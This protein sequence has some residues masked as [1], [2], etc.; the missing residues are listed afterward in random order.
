MPVTAKDSDESSS[1]KTDELHRALVQRVISSGTFATT[2]RLSSFLQYV[3]DQTLKGQADSLNEQRIGEAVFRRSHDYDSSIDGIV[4]TQGSRLRQ[5]LD[6]YFSEEGTN[7]PI[8][9][10]IPR[11]CYVP[12]FEPRVPDVPSGALP[13][14]PP[15]L[16]PAPES[17]AA[18]QDNKAQSTIAA[19]TL[20]KLGWASVSVLAVVILLLIVRNGPAKEGANRHV[21]AHP[22]WNQMF[23]S[24]QHTLIVP[25]DSG[26]V[27]WEGLTHEKIGL[28]EFL[29]GDYRAERSANPAQ[30][31][32]NDLS[33]RR[34]T[35]FVDLEALQMLTRVAQSQKSELEMRYARD[36]KT[37]DLKE[38]NV[39]LV[40]ASE[41]NP[42]VE[43]YEQGMNFR[44]S[45]DP[46]T[47]RAS[48]INRSPRGHEPGSWDLAAGG[49]YAIVAF[50]P[51]LRGNGN[52][53]LIGGTS[54]TGT[55]TALDF[56]SDD[57]QL[58]PFLKSIQRPDGRL[59]H[60]EV[61]LGTTS[62]SASAV[63]SNVLAWRALN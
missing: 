3:C 39:I 35:S 59:P 15:T 10:V 13:P 2:E 60:F 17:A 63:R 36:L 21:T 33:Q 9:I 52:G 38:G 42:W 31:I 12:V 23:V 18:S 24:G 40:G 4:R 26:L 41:A 37:N 8:R 62:V 1:V 34:Y 20:S 6:R 19:S 27:I 7:E 28:A 61:V 43:L 45:K 16:L 11:G 22:L 54:M 57:T 48:I 49:A 47:G 53:L 56:I 5:R 32:A 44:F 55:E 58:L 51:G 46:V 29:K 14:A 30:S 50:L 25:G